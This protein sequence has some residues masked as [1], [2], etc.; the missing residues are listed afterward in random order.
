MEKFMEEPLHDHV[1]QMHE[2]MWAACT[3]SISVGCLTLDEIS[4]RPGSLTAVNLCIHVCFSVF[5]VT[6][7]PHFNTTCSPH[8]YD[9]LDKFHHDLYSDHPTQI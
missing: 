5:F 6:Y 4:Q 1:K 8:T 9:L 3:L 2:C 7:S